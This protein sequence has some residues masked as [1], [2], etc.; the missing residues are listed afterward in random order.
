MKL[1]I[2]IIISLFL[3]SCGTGFCI[4]VDG[5]YQDKQGGFEYCYDPS[6]GILT[7]SVSKEKAVIVTSDELQQIKKES[8]EV[9]TKS[10]VKKLLDKLIEKVK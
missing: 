10:D 1:F 8:E 4:K 3:I 2:L 5:K 6:K 9:S 7:N